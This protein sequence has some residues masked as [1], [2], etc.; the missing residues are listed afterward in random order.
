VGE[1]RGRGSEVK[2]SVVFSG[3]RVLRLAITL[4][5]ANGVLKGND[6]G[7]RPPEKVSTEKGVVL[8]M[9]R[10]KERQRKGKCVRGAQLGKGEPSGGKKGMRRLGGVRVNDCHMRV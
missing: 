3:K 1:T 9:P 6:D 2:G 10:V 5:G 4:E 7:T 8:V